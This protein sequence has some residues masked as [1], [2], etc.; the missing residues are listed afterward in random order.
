MSSLEGL[1][2][3][4]N[5]ERELAT[6]PEMWRRARVGFVGCCTSFYVAQPAAGYTSEAMLAT[7]RGVDPDHPFFLVR[8]IML[9][10]S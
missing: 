10:H 1:L 4:S 9:D 2:I 7:R 6:Q 3:M 8:S 5:F